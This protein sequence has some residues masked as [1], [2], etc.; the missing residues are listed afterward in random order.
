MSSTDAED[1]FLQVQGDVLSLLNTTRP[2][3]A[4]YLR[5]RSLTSSP[6]SPEL[7][8][9]RTELE[10]SLQDLS[11]DLQDLVDSVK[12]VEHDPYR[13]GIEID[14]VERRRRLVGEVG[15]EIEDMREELAKAVSAAP[16]AG[17]RSN[18][19][20]M[21]ESLPP[22]SAFE[23][24][25][26]DYAEFEQQRQLELMHEQDEALDDVFQTVGNLRRQADDMGRELE[27]QAGLLTDVDTMAERV[28][29]KLQSGMKKVGW[30]LKKNEGENLYMPAPNSLTDPNFCVKIPCR[31]AA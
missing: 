1:P 13:Y 12:A 28:G 10:S 4:S 22:P 11:T 17:E 5:I 8:Q 9:A 24:G 19:A 26:D 3:F 18:N 29:G 21:A 31:V 7:I 27:D 25:H 2:L 23:P 20:G 16:V 14:E 30:V 6:T 15:G